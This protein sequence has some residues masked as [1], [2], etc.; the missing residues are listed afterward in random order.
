MEVDK[1]YE[2]FITLCE[3]TAKQLIDKTE[4]PLNEFKL[5]SRYL[6]QK[7]ILSKDKL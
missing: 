6:A 1:K 4:T 3:L 2:D 5:S 7:D